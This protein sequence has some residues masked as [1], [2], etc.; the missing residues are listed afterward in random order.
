M[1]K[2][3]GDN[4]EAINA[5]YLLA[6]T[7]FKKEPRINFMGNLTPEIFFD[8][9]GLYTEK[10]NDVEI[11]YKRQNDR[12]DKEINEAFKNINNIYAKVDIIHIAGYA[13]CGK[14][15]YIRHLLWEKANN[16]EYSVVDYEGETDV[17]NA[18][19]KRIKIEM[20]NNFDNII[21][22]IDAIISENLFDLS[23]FERIYNALIFLSNAK[24]ETDIKS[25][26]LILENLQAKFN[27]K[28][29]FCY[30]LL[31]VDFF[32]QLNKSITS[33]SNKPFIIIF[34]NIDSISSTKEEIC[35]LTALKNFVNDCNFFFGSNINSFKLY[36]GVQIRELLNKTK[37]I[38]F[39][40]TRI[41]T[42]KRYLELEPDMENIYGWTSLEMPEHY[43]SHREIINKRYNFY[44]R[45]ESGKVSKT[46]NDLLCINEF[47][48]LVYANYNFKRLFNGSTRICFDT[49]YILHEKYS[50][51][52]SLI[53]EGIN[54]YR[55]Y[56][57]KKIGFEALRG[58]QGIVLSLLLNYF[59]DNNIYTEKLHLSEC[60]LD[61]K[62]SLSRIILTIIRE[63]GGSCR[64]DEIFNMLPD[65][66]CNEMTCTITWDLSEA[67]RKEWRR[68]I[69]FNDRNLTS[70]E[71]LTKQLNMYLNGEK[72]I[73]KYTIID[74]CRSGLSYLEYVVPHFEFMLSRLRYEKEKLR[75]LSYQPLFCEN[76]LND[77]K[78]DKFERKY[79]FEK[80][81]DM[82]FE[83]VRD[84]CLNS[85]DF[86]QKV[87]KYL[88]I[89]Q[90][91][92]LKNSFFNYHTVNRD[93]T[94]GIRQSYESRLIFSHIGYIESYRRYVLQTCNLESEDYRADI[95]SRIILRIEQY[96]SLYEN[97]EI[98]HQTLVQNDVAIKLR[99]RIGIIRRQKYRDFD[100]K[101]E[102]PDA[103]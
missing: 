59:K 31:V 101:I 85:V 84:C 86:A 12:F 71:D 76:S 30:F 65:A 90:E 103:E 91:E 11:E 73:E 8:E 53:A 38:L 56:T 87:I 26:D 49:L 5:N 70:A 25:R 46:L 16:I 62:I 23:R 63:K 36:K 68:L 83:V 7:P 97:K 48:K 33:C 69:V 54:M 98:C 80:K 79:Y 100:T 51:G 88:N 34:D 93:G 45:M 58:A 9:D 64:I 61:Y 10:T 29:D 2:F 24:R 40:T 21:S 66:Y 89:S 92:Y 52:T 22:F 44:N 3:Y 4:I 95:N 77:L 13:G 67:K 57:Q 19:L 20:F 41:V 60:Q 55:K 75:S 82:V 28:E 74:I 17:S 99:E 42:I 78:E 35:I 39:M 47:A 102:I 18:I 81:I 72:N 15:T 50:T 32:I 1:N 96:L 14:T 6:A 27:S 37:F 43:Y 94:P